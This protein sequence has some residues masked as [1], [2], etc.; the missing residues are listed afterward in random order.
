MNDRETL[1]HLGIAVLVL[2]CVMFLLI[3]ISNMIA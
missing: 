2:V 3:L 1:R